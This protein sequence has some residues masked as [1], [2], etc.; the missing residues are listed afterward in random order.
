MW[1][2]WRYRWWPRRSRSHWCLALG[3]VDFVGDW[4]H[5]HGGGPVPTATVACCGNAV[6][7][8]QVVAALVGNID[9]VRHR[10][11]RDGKGLFLRSRSRCCWSRRRSGLRCAT[12]IGYI[13]LVGNRVYRHGIGTC[14]GGDGGRGVGGAVDHCHV[15]GAAK[16]AT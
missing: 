6:D 11:R 8:G 9:F 5:R 14:S 13:D 7:H 3:N 12:C 10:V 15:V 2:G 4:I 1:R 16:L